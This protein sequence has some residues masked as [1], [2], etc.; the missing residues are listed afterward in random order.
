MVWSARRDWTREQALDAD[1]R[2]WADCRPAAD[3]RATALT[4]VVVLRRRPARVLGWAWLIA[5]ALILALDPRIYYL[6]PAFPMSFA[7]GAVIWEQW[8]ARPRLGWIKVAYPAVMV[9]LGVVLAPLAIPVLPVE[10]FI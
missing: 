9:L 4:H 8:L 5:A 6:W 10:R 1:L 2:V 3:S 7:G